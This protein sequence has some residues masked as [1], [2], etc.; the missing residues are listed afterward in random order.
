LSLFFSRT[1]RVLSTQS[2]G[3][4][5]FLRLDYV[6][7]DIRSIHEDAIALVPL[8]IVLYRLNA[9]SLVALHFS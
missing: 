4:N 7:N 8:T 3:K 6:T 5:Y 2:V 9:H 1:R